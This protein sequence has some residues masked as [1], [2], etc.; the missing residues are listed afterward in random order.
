[1]EKFIIKVQDVSVADSGVLLQD[2]REMILD[3]HPDVS[4]ELKRDDPEAQDFGATLALLLGTPALIAVAK[5]I[6]AWLKLHHSSKLRIEKDGRVVAE[7]LTGAQVINLAK[8]LA[9]KK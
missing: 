6:E 8:L 2:L 4:A 9:H 1:M 7:N 3:S 5:G